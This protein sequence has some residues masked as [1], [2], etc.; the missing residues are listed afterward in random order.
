MSGSKPVWSFNEGILHC[1]NQDVKWE[2]YGAKRVWRFI[3]GRYNG[4]LQ[5]CFTVHVHLPGDKTEM[6][7]WV[8]FLNKLSRA[9]IQCGC[10]S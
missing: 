6:A 7:A 8:A 4:V 3:G 5:Y 2:N 10:I 9:N 1:G